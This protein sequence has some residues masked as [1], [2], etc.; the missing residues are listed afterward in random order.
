MAV[1]ISALTIITQVEV[2]TAMC[3]A[4]WP[5]GSS[6]PW[7]AVSMRYSK[8]TTTNPPPKPNNT[9]VTPVMQPK[10]ASKR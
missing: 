4:D 8:G 1:A 5:I 9:A 6:A 2:A 10:S 3:I 7:L